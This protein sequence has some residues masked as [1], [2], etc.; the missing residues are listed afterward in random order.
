LNK[1]GDGIL[2][3]GQARGG[4]ISLVDIRPTSNTAI[5]QKNKLN[6]QVIS[7]RALSKLNPAPVTAHRRQPDGSMIRQDKT[8]REWIECRVKF[9]WIDRMER[10]KFHHRHSNLKPIL[11][12]LLIHVQ[13]GEVQGLIECRLGLWKEPGG[14]GNKA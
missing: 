2:L 12:I 3:S 1:I 8:K 14:C 11:F 7:L 9:T 6:G 5:K 4:R 13:H 10:I